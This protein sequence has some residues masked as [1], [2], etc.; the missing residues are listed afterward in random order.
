MSKWKKA[1]LILAIVMVLMVAGLAIVVPMLLNIDRYRQQVT[2]QIEQ[3]TGKQAQIGH[4]DLTILP[5]VAIRVDDFSLSN[6]ND[7]PPGNFVQAR[8]IYAVV[9]AFALL[10]RQV[11]ITS[12]ELDDLTLAL[13]QDSHG[14]WNFENPS[15][16]G[17]PAGDPPGESGASFRLGIISKVTVERGQVS[18]AKLLVSGVP[19]PSL[20]EVHGV[21]M[22]LR[23]VDLTAL[24]TASLRAPA[25][26]P[27]A[28][29]T[30]WLNTMAYAADSQGPP[31]AE[32]TLQADAL[33]VG[34]ISVTRLKSKIRLFPKQ[35]FFDDL[36]LKCYG[37]SATGNFSLDFGGANLAYRADAKI[38]SVNVAQFLNAFS[39]A[40]GMMTGTLD[41]TS[42]M[43]GLV[44]HSADPLAGVTG[45]GQASIRNGRLPSLQ[46]NS[47]LR[48]LAQMANLGP[49]KGDPASFS[50]LSADFR[51]ADSRLSSNKI[52]LVGNG[53]NVDGSGSMTMAGE[54][55]LDYQGDASLAVNGS[56]PLAT[57]L[58][59]LA[60]G[61]LENGKLTFPFTVQGTFA[62]PRFALKRGTEGPADIRGILSTFGKKVR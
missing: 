43:K 56:N 48:N 54:G 24:T 16:K 44:S 60:G 26:A 17:T 59:G 45:T 40:K 6:P 36:D 10:H 18:A 4:L 38:Q 3:E 57:V 5:Q 50:S 42:Q 53:V 27:L 1:A 41:G 22:D 19:G 21:A 35:A 39:Q 49:A 23:E 37:G 14:K 52:T 8:K 31:A 13:V 47:N 11:N 7:F 33:Q 12:L 9:D 55:S 58:A 28:F 15:A 34:P 51:I 2:A 62:K 46:L 29:V 61:K 30:G 20:M 32:G 25:T